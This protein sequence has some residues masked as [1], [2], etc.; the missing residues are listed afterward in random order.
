MKRLLVLLSL[1]AVTACGVGVESTPRP[2]DRNARPF[3]AAVTQAS[4]A[5][6]GTG[7]AVVYL[8]R[9]QVLVAVLRRVPTPPTP[10]DVLAALAAGPNSREQ[11]AGFVSAVPL[12]AKVSDRSRV[13]GILVVEVPTVDTAST[14]TDEVLGYGQMVVT[15]ASLPEVAGVRFVRNGRAIGVPRGDGSLFDGALTRRDYAELF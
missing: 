3:Q 9:D 13:P 1:G 11:D 12:K 5:P 10:A 14:R 7:R 8:A 4:P 2:L 6:T 15:L